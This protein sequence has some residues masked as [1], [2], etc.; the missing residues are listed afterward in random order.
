MTV[1]KY[2]EQAGAWTDGTN[3]VKGSLI[4]RHSI[5]NNHRTTARGR[6]SAFEVE[7]YFLNK[8]G[9]TASVSGMSK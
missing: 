5:E 1:I 2:D 7:S 9:V 8:L 6:L 3:Y 4:R